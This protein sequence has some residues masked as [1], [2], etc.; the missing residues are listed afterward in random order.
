MDA[1]EVDEFDLRGVC[2][3]PGL[4]DL[5]RKLKQRSGLTLR[6]L[7]E[8]ARARGVFLARST[9]SDMLR[10]TRLPSRETL[11]AFVRACGAPETDVHAWLEARQRAE[12][13]VRP[14]DQ[15]PAPDPADAAGTVRTR[16]KAVAPRLGRLRLARSWALAGAVTTSLVAVTAWALS[17]AVEP[18]SPSAA[19]SRSS[20]SP[21]SS[22]TADRSTDSAARK[23]LRGFAEIR[24]AR[25]P[26]LC[27]TEGR[28]TRGEY[29]NAVAAQLPCEEARPPHTY[30]RPVDTAASSTPYFIEWQHPQHG[31]G[32]L[33]QRRK[34]PGQD[35]L[36]PWPW[37]SCDDTRAYQHFRIEPVGPPRKATGMRYRLRLEG[38]R[39][40][41]GLRDDSTETGADMTVEPCSGAPDQ[42]FLISAAA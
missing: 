31:R 19:S 38:T 41:V 30:L 13:G 28:D 33:T 15:A 21:A 39:D 32:C 24:P 7:E 20:A 4:V 12:D 36:E 27:L 23:S 29:R 18:S 8:R 2:D 6:E 34:G 42:E 17:A 22:P 16:S 37:K 3:T 10:G 5:L 35:L 11:A 1:D 26:H 9:V 14:S 40:C 25:T